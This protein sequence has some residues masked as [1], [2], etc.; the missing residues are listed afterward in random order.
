MINLMTMM[1]AAAL[2]ACL[3]AYI[4][5]LSV[6]KNK[7]MPYGT[8]AVNIAGAFLMGMVAIMVAENTQYYLLPIHNSLWIS[9]ICSVKRKQN[10][11]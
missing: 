4:S 8:I 7:D 5:Q 6:F 3:R 11:F 1:V 9:S 10:Y 2:G